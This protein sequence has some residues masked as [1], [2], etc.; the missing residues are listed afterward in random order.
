MTSAM[1]LRLL[2]SFPFI[3]CSVSPHNSLVG[4]MSAMSWDM[5]PALCSAL[6]WSAGR[7]QCQSNRD[8]EQESEDVSGCCWPS[9][10]AQCCGGKARTGQE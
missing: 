7:V 9:P 4:L 5:Q 1:V 2:A 6:M 3:G 10:R 8:N